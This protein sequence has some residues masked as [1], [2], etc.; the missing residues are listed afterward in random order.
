MSLREGAPN[1]G[2]PDSVPQSARDRGFALFIVLMAILLLVAAGAMMSLHILNRMALIRDQERNLHLQALVDS[3]YAYAASRI[4]ADRGYSAIVELELDGGVVEVDVE[5]ITGLVVQPG[6]R[7]IGLRAEY[8]GEVRRGR[9][10]L[11]I[12]PD[13]RLE[14]FGIEP[15]PLQQSDH[16]G[17]E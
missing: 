2:A 9:G 14:L 4:A 3:G 17:F 15:V 11:R 6:L 13:G 5:V 7:Q 10:L 16:I 12:R 8:R 1:S